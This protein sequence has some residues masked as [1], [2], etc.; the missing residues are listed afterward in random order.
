MS[1]PRCRQGPKIAA[2][3]MY[4]ETLSRCCLSGAQHCLLVYGAL[5]YNCQIK[6]GNRS[7]VHW[8]IFLHGFGFR[9]FFNDNFLKA[10]ILIFLFTKNQQRISSWEDLKKNSKNTVHSVFSCNKYTTKRSCAWSTYL[11]HFA[12]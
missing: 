8:Q 9:L 10:I 11:V 4:L 6:N 5:P 1:L 2:L 3:S 7:L 12:Y